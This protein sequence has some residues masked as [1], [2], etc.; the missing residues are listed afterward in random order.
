MDEA[1]GMATNEQTG[2]KKRKTPNLAISN[3]ASTASST[4]VASSRGRQE[5]NRQ[6]AKVQVLR[7]NVKLHIWRT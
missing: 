1:G 2:W 3:E 5:T 7:A 4:P 6:E